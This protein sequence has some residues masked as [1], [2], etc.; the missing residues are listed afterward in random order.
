M[1][2]PENPEITLLLKAWADG[3]EVAHERLIPIIYNELH[4]IAS[5]V[6]YRAGVGRRGVQDT[7]QTT[8]LVHEAWLRF[9]GINTVDWQGRSHFFA[10][11]AQLMRRI[12][13]D[14][15]RA[16]LAAKRGGPE[17]QSIRVDPDD[18]AAPN[19]ASARE[20]V[21]L[22]DALA[23]L[24]Q[25]DPRRARI[26]ELRIFAG[27]SVAETAEMTGLSQASVL[28]DWKVAKAWLMRELS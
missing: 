22:D 14:R 10:V 8:G 4:L 23:A 7:L 26:V 19:T 9:A 25:F 15:S 3:D 11:A 28:R 12:L 1:S 21:A 20:V 16:R 27:L 5:R 17:A 2:T 24:T 18:V 6:R 13:V